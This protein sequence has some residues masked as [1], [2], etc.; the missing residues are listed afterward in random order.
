MYAQIANPKPTALIKNANAMTT[1]AHKNIGDKVVFLT[2]AQEKY[3]VGVRCTVDDD[4]QLAFF[5]FL[6]EEDEHKQRCRIVEIVRVWSHVISD[7]D[8][9]VFPPWLLKYHNHETKMVDMALCRRDSVPFLTWYHR[10]WKILPLSEV[11]TFHVC[12]RGAVHLLEWLQRQNLLSYNTQTAD[13]LMRAAARGNS[14][15]CFSCYLRLAKGHTRA[16]LGPELLYA[17][18][19]S[20]KAAIVQE[21]FANLEKSALSTV[22]Y[23]QLWHQVTTCGSIEVAHY[24]YRRSPS[25]WKRFTLKAVCHVKL[26]E[27]AVI[28]HKRID[29]IT[30]FLLKSVQLA[31]T[32]DKQALAMCQFSESRWMQDMSIYNKQ[33]LVDQLVKRGFVKTLTWMLTRPNS[34]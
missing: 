12:E 25:A 9:K 13:A 7:L 17:S 8:S 18:I 14:A 15:E 2:A 30:S 3:Y 28:S 10:R 23:T 31:C 32:T 21:I 26:L 29:D 16:F 24:L 20:R 33:K 11:Q 34:S 6:E 27:L 5:K 19:A 22:N 4:D 1:Q